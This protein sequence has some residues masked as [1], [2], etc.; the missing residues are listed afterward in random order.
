MRRILSW[1]VISVCI[2]GLV[3]C[4]KKPPKICS[5]AGLQQLTDQVEN[6]AGGQF[7]ELGDQVFVDIPAWYL[8]K[9]SSANTTPAG[10]A[11]LNKIAHRF[12][13]YTTTAVHVTA[14]TGTLPLP[15]ENKV[16]SAQ[17]A[18][19]ATDLLLQYGVSRLIYQNSV[20]IG[21]KCINCR[22]NRIEIVTKRLS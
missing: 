3:G 6:Q 13:C 12:S 14:Y 9:G 5:A 18:R 10:N 11:L 15:R 17:R 1:F 20:A 16:L 19:V 4:S 21:N 22:L 7:V 2:I 8:F